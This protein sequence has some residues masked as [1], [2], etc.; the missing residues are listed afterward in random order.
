M[1]TKHKLLNGVN[2][3]A[4][5]VKLTLGTKGRTV[6]FKDDNN[7][8]HITK[9]GVTVARYVFSED[10]FENMIIT[11]LR[12]ASMKT[13]LSSGDGPQP[14]YAKV[15]TPNGFTTIGELKVGD[16][17]CGTNGTIQNV[18][19]I[20]PKG[21]KEIYKVHFSDGR[22]VECCNDHLWNVTSVLHNTPKNMTISVQDMIDS[23]KI[24]V[25]KN[26]FVTYGYYTPK[27]IVDFNE[28]N[29]PLDPYL[30]GVLLGDGTLSD[31]GDIEISLG[32]NKEHIIDKLILPE[33]TTINV[34]WNDDKSYFRIKVSK[35]IKKILK[36]LGL[37]KTN[38]YTKHIPS[39]YLY[40]SID[41]RKA[42]L[43]GLLD[44][45]GYINDRGLFEFST[46]SDSL[47]DDFMTLTRSLGYSLY[48]K[49]H[50]RDKDNSS[51]SNTSIHRIYQLKGYKYGDKIVK[52]EATG[53]FTE[54]Q[55]IKVSNPDSL[56][57]TDNFI[58]TH[59]T[60]T[61]MILAQYL[62]NEG[63]KLL[64][65]GMS[66]YELSKQID[67]A[68]ADVINYIKENSISIEDKPHL[69]KEIASISSNDSNI[70]SFI[71]NII[72]EIGLYGDIEVKPS[73]YSE[74]KVDKTIGMKLHKGYFEPFMVNNIKESTFT[75]ENPA[76][77]IVEG[78]IRSM[79]DFKDYIE[80]LNG[81]PLV[82]FC[83]DIS[84]ITLGQIKRW[85]DVSGYPI[86]FVENDGFG[87]RKQILMNDLAALT[88][89]MIVEPTT[90][91]SKSNLGYAG[92]IQVDQLFTRVSPRED[93][94]DRQLVDDIIED[95]K[96][97]LQNNEENDDLELSNREKRFYEKRLANLTGGVAVIHAGGRTEMEM[98]ELKDRLDDAVLAVS[99]AIKMGVTIGGGYTFINCQNALL[100]HNNQKG[101]N[102][103]LNALE[104]P[105]KQLLINADLINNYD[106]YKNSLLKNKA[107]DL[108]D[109]KIYNL[110][111]NNYTVYDPASVLIDSISNAVAVSKS[112]LS[113]KNLIY[114]GK[115][116]R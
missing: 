106:S 3:L 36:D 31:S 81:K 77:L 69:L 35:E 101:Y 24:A 2:L 66:Y 83:D 13:M 62:I 48:Y 54:M 64:D 44:T 92:E 5:T 22:I 96:Y 85:L 102:L 49:L 87:D 7:K 95:I 63:V 21:E 61:T 98:K 90:P 52:I 111:K 38:S 82:I 115:I 79:T 88:S 11:V 74:T 12:E 9:D 116:I 72:N 53:E 58:V 78:V 8:P 10:D 15:L 110:N 71:Y 50:T 84:D 19:G 25:K 27:T 108:R 39:I 33:N 47:K 73:Q 103:V 37:Y 109:G 112:L 114:E 68:V 70:G 45:D 16:N 46:V 30:L 67:N 4:D 29:L 59:N 89:A 100:K 80:Y 1:T 99:S 107:V 55:C 65:E 57:I 28:K 18:I 17:I 6:L 40:S 91:F 20:F 75:A 14:L 105:F 41:T 113:V 60:T 97:R 104:I 94:I 42:L 51:Y 26:G 23:N 93:K 86:C 32:I 34:K 76:V 56:Y 43:Q